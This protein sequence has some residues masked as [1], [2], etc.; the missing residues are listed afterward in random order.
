MKVY[1]LWAFFS[2]GRELCGV[3]TSHKK[4]NEY[5]LKMVVN[6]EHYVTETEIDQ[7]A[8]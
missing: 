2:H 7:R 1:L 6:V 8:V 3:F 4:A 5:A